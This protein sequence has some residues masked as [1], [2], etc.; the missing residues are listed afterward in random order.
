LAKHVLNTGGDD[1]D[2]LL[3][4]IVCAEDQYR[5]TSLINDA[6]GT[7]LALSSYIPF[8]LKNGRAF[9]FSLFSYSDEDLGLQY[10]LV[11]NNSNLEQPNLNTGTGKGLFAEIDVDENVKLIRE[12]PRTD[13]FLIVKGEE[14]HNFQFRIS[15]KLKSIDVILQVQPVSPSE[16]PSRRN[17]IF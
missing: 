13:Y 14:L 6:L 8:N 1:L 9:T 17:L 12:L 7:E 11:P 4:G 3:F 5:M 16:L 15:D 2:F 10:H